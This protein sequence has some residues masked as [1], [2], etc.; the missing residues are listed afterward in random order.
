MH[1]TWKLLKRKPAY[2]RN[3]SSTYI[4]GRGATAKSARPKMSRR[5]LASLVSQN[6]TPLGFAFGY[7][8]QK[9]DGLLM[10]ATPEVLPA[11]PAEEQPQNV[12]GRR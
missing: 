2:A 4:P 5:R 6:E 1:T 10:I 12:R 3:V 7:H 9:E 11:L 8:W